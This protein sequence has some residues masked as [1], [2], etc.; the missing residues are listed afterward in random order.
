VVASPHP[1]DFVASLHGASQKVGTITYHFHKSWVVI[2]S[3]NVDV[4]SYV[5]AAH[6]G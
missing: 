4:T 3:V 5:V 2:N 1:Q 6:R